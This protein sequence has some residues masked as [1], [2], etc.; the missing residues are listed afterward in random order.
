MEPYVECLLIEQE[1]MLIVTVLSDG[2][3]EISIE[4][5][6]WPESDEDETRRVHNPQRRH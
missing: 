1:G 2:T 5:L 3:V 4:Y 6:T